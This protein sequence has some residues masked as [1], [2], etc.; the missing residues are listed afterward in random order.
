MK[1]LK[2]CV[3]AASAANSAC[4]ETAAV[5][6]AEAA[7]TGGAISFR[8]VYETSGLTPGRMI[9]Q[10]KERFATSPERENCLTDRSNRANR[11]SL[12]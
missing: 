10:K 2:T 3:G 4:I 9:C 6:A 1:S 11:V 5:I 8:Q 7:P 12:A